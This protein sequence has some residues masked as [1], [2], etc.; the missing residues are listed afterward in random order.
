MFS[1]EE[2][3][4]ALVLL[5]DDP[6]RASIAARKTYEDADD[7]FIYGSV[8]SALSTV[9]PSAAAR[10]Q[11]WLGET[12]EQAAVRLE[13]FRAALTRRDSRNIEEK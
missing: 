6:E 12:D 7:W 13:E 5:L 4:Q 9:S 10:V 3:R 1:E 8:F 11:E 2:F